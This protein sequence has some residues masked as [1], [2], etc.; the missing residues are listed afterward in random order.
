M[1]F[2]CLLFGW[3]ATLDL[4]FLYVPSASGEIRRQG[5][6]RVGE[7][8]SGIRIPYI[9]NSGQTDPAVAYYAQT[10][11]GTV[12]VTRDGRIVYSLPGE[13]DSA[14][15]ARSSGRRGGWSL[16]ERP[17]GA[18]TH[19]RGSD[20]SPT[21]VS[22]FLGDD[23]TRWGSGLATFEGVS[24]GEVWPG[25]SL[26]L[27]AHGKNVEKLFTVE[28]GGDPSR[29][30]MSVE[31]AWSLRVNEAGALVAGTGLG[32]MTF[33]PPV[34]F[35]ERQGA[36][37]LVKA[38]YELYGRR[39]G[40]RLSDYDPAVP[41]E[42]DPLL[43]AT[44][45]G[46]SGFDEAAA[47]AIHPTSGDVYVAGDTASTN[48]PGTTGGAQAANGGGVDAFV[49][50]LNSTLTTL[51]Q[52]T[53]LGG[54]GTDVAFALAIHPTSGDV[55]VAGATASTNFPATTGGAQA[56]NGGGNDALVA[57]LTVGLV[58]VE[59]TPTNTPA[60]PVNIPTTSEGGLLALGL[61]LAALGYL[62]LRSLSSGGSS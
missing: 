39:Y 5:A 20:R 59:P 1:G 51:T 17:V 30:R 35:Q 47:L 57:Q 58:A 23:P 43:Q 24:L 29:I 28:P 10:F 54:S 8:L 46:G 22:Y 32:D 26:D 15:A 34:A 13:K 50:R 60:L 41:V 38:A 9:A 19:P 31:G 7:Y 45:L 61:L 49:A 56:A 3:L 27:R 37:R 6:K 12:F 14:S 42:I 40:F 4:V 53:Y 33:T 16:I 36:R 44:Y 25:I 18:R 52:A 62:L 2:R 11:A 48:F 21:G 55:Y